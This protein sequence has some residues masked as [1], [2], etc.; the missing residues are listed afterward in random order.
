MTK[1]GKWRR[2]SEFN[3][4]V[5]APAAAAAAPV[6]EKASLVPPNPSWGKTPVAWSA[7]L[8]DLDETLPQAKKPRGALSGADSC[9]ATGGS[10]MGFMGGRSRTKDQV[11]LVVLSPP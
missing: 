3:V 4:A 10:S 8:D 2:G 5:G 6:K 11:S 9:G 1:E 7:D